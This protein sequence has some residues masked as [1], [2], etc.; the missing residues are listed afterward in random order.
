M[1]KKEQ[2]EAPEIEVLELRMAGVI[3]ASEPGS[4]ENLD[5]WDE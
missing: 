5:G 1:I 4:G 3:A 2:Y